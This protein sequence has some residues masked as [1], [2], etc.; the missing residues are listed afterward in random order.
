MF[1]MNKI[2]SGLKGLRVARAAQIGA[3]RRA[4]VASLHMRIPFTAGGREPLRPAG[5]P[6]H[7]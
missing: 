3:D 2:N 5:L 7:L 4:T 1:F 6:I